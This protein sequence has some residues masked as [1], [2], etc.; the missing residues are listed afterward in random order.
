M[1]ASKFGGNFLVNLLGTWSDA[2]GSYRSYPTG[3]KISRFFEKA[4]LGKLFKCF[5]EQVSE[6]YLS[7]VK[8][9]TILP[10]NYPS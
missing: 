9:S 2:S 3:G 1:L 6:K 5:K 7:F 10:S 8:V 4:I